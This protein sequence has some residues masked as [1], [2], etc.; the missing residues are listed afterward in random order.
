VVASGHLASDGE[1]TYL[2]GENGISRLNVSEQDIDLFY[3]LSSGT[4]S[5]GDMV[6]LPDGNVLVAHA[7]RYDRRLILIEPDG[8]VRWERSYRNKVDGAVD[9]VL[10]E[11]QPYLISNDM[12]GSVSKVSIFLIDLANADLT[13]IFAG[14]TRSSS[15]H[16]STTF[17]AGDNT[18]LVDI[19]GGSLA[20]L[21][22]QQATDAILYSLDGP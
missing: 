3:E 8:T 10:L 1:H 7:D 2:Y 22:I 16:T 20:A 13:K 5:L 21:D 4:L 15:Q 11:D 6:V 12:D 9:L 17:A 18:I 19:G 14:G